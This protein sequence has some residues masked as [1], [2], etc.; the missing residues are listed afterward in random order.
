MRKVFSDEDDIIRRANEIL[1][2]Q[3]VYVS[4]TQLKYLYSIVVS[5]I[6][7]SLKL[8]EVLGVV[9][10]KVGTAYVTERGLKKSINNARA[11]DRGLK[12]ILK[13]K[14]SILRNTTDCRFKK[15]KRLRLSNRLTSGLKFKS[16]IENQNNEYNA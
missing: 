15:Q 7:E 12:F 16:V 14:I 2:E 13:E 8:P 10:P 5:F 3:G 6:S 1:D 9:L 4:K 11:S